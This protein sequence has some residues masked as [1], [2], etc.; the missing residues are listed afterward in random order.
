MN[1]TG[2]SATDSVQEL[3]RVAQPETGTHLLERPQRF[4][5]LPTW[6]FWR[7][8]ENSRLIRWPVRLA[9]VAAFVLAVVV[10]VGWIVAGL[11]PVVAITITLGLVERYVRRRALERRALVQA[12][13]DSA[14]Y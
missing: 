1:S 13:D 11:L 3:D 4:G 7:D 12:T 14:I 8:K 6:G 5:I 9:I 10:D 2:E